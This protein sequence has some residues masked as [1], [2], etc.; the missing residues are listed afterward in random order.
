MARK[1]LN[2]KVAIIGSAVFLIFILVIIVAF[3]RI[4]QDP[5]KFI[6]EGDAAWL[7]KDYDKAQQSYLKAHRFAKAGTI[8]K[9]ILTKL[10]DVYIETGQWPKVRGCWE[11]IINIDTK[12]VEARLGR[13]KYVYIVADNYAGAGRKVSVMWKEVQSQASELIGIVENE[14]LLRTKRADLEPS[15]GKEEK[16]LQSPTGQY[17][18]PYLYLLKGRAAFELAQMGAVTA[19]DELLNQAVGDL[20][21]VLQLDPNNVDAYWYLAQAAVEKG[22]ILALRGNLEE[23]SKATVKAN[24]FLQQAVKVADTVPK[25]HINLLTYKFALARESDPKMVKQQLKSLEPDY[26]SLVNKFPSSAEAFAAMAR[27]YSISSLYLDRNLSLE[28]FDKATAAAEKAIELDK[29][30]VAYALTVADLCYRRYSVYGQKSEIQKA[31]TIAKSALEFPDAKDTVGPQSVANRMNRFL[32]CSFLANC[33]IEQIIEPF[34]GATKSQI[35]G[36]LTDAEQVVHEIEQIFGSGEE[37]QVVKWQG[38]LELAK[39]NTE[40]AVKKLNA[41]YEQIKVSNSPEQRDAQLSYTLAKVFQ[42]TSEL[43]AVIEFLASALD[44]GIEM[45]KPEAILDYLEVLGRLD[46]WSHVLSPVNPYNI[47]AFEQKFGPSKRSQ[48]LRIKALIGTN[49]VSEAEE[50][51]AKLNQ[52]DPDVIKVNLVLVEEK[53]SQ[54]RAAIVQKRAAKDRGII[55]TPADVEEQKDAESDPA[56]RLMAAELNKHSQLRAELVQKLLLTEPNSVEEDIVTAICKS[57]IAQGQMDKAK[58]LVGLFL[59]HFR[60]IQQFYSI[61]NCFLS[62]ILRT[63]RCKD[64]RR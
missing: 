35:E 26:L 2:K 14:S 17:L 44:A 28:N 3:L 58:E 60:I 8:R 52:D 43:G 55:V 45:V 20:E 51:L 13:L 38:M 12:N 39:G 36:W 1:R 7:A 11:Q 41:A 23:K 54:I 33:Y 22:K 27:F 57:C 49:Q 62:R 37:P 48:I 15:F 59:K 56:V 32:L 6:K 50:E 18:G 9:D 46:M 34:E 29:E 25:S 42:N 16:Y 19:P 31:M 61:N 21:K 24:E 63:F 10:A 47:D 64:V 5:D 4:G 40:I 30:N 53:I